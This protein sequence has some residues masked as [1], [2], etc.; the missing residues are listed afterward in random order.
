MMMDGI[1]C[2]RC[3]VYMGED[4]GHPRRC[5]L[6]KAVPAPATKKTQCTVCKKWVKL[7]GIDDH[8]KAVHEV[9]S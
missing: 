1:L 5:R 6:C 7:A 3:G 8:M 9:Q 2:E 4:V